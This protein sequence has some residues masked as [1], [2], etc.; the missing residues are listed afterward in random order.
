[1]ARIFR[2]PLLVLALFAAIAPAATRAAEDP[3]AFADLP[4][5]LGTRSAGVDWPS[6]LGPE[7]NSR[8][9]ETGLI[10][11]RAGAAP[12]IVWQTAIGESYSAPSISHGRLVHFDRVDDSHRLTCRNSETGAELWHRDIAANY[13]DMLG[14]NRGPRCTPVIDGDRVYVVSPEGGLYCFRL[15]DGE[16]LWNVDTIEKFNVVKNF[17]GVG[18]TPLVWGDLLI[19]N[20][21][22]SPEGSPAD[23]YAAAGRVEG[24]GS[25][26]VG[27]DKLTG[28][29]RWQ[30]TDELASYASPVVA[31]IG[32]RPW[33]LVFARGGLLGLDPR[34][35]AA[36]FHFPWRAVKLESVNASTPVVVGDQAFISESYSLGSAVL[37]VKPGGYDVVWQDEDASRDHALELHWN[38]AVHHDGYLFASSGQHAATAE[39]R[40]V[41]LA[42]GAVKWSQPGLGRASLL[43]VDGCLVCLAEEGELRVLR[44]TPE[45]YEVIVDITPRD[46]AG[47]PLLKDPAW[48][49]PVL[50]HGL[51]YVRGADRLVCLEVIPAAP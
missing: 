38:T 19:V 35:G 12:R 51:L 10:I 29:V 9:P 26:V 18:S 41:E 32:G 13:E 1:M 28:A 45:K 20:I 36:D 43:Y 16:P 34:T 48:A 42:T 6:F 49:A 47:E 5:D 21:G 27:F 2:K 11:N 37:R 40:C 25:G 50:S 22:G 46:D 14:Y 30:A 39:L 23:V 8:S 44:A 15:T 17:F 33:C 4:P 24:N 3:A 31:E 7:R